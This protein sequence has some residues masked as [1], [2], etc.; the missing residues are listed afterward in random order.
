MIYVAIGI[1]VLFLIL[2]VVFIAAPPEQLV[3]LLTRAN[4]KDK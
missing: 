3:R 4:K 2:L 1:L